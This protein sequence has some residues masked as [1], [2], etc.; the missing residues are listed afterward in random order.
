LVVLSNYVQLVWL[1]LA[2]YATHQYAPLALA[3]AQLSFL[4]Y[5]FLN[6]TGYTDVVIGLGCLTGLRLPE[7]FNQPWMSTSFLDFWRRWHMSMS[8]WF[9]TYVFTPLSAYLMRRGRLSR[10]V[11]LEGVIAFFVTFFLVGLW[12]G[13]TASFVVCGVLQGLGASVNQLYRDRMR[14]ALG[15][16]RFARLGAGWLYTVAS[17]VLTLAY[18][19]VSVSTL[20]MSLPQMT[21]IVTRLGLGGNLI[22]LGALLLMLS[23]VV[24]VVRLLSSLPSFGR[25]PVPAPLITAAYVGAAFFLAE[26]YAFLSPT[27]GGGIFYGKF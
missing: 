11:D 4:V 22:A 16:A 27:P 6:F 7:N 15:R 5:L 8:G 19:C 13:T 1:N 9:K 12:H 21:A 10:A 3:G 18:V 2:D 24:P 26:F 14:R 25:W 20:W 23:L 17:A